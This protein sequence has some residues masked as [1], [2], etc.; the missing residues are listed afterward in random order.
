MP[1]LEEERPTY[2]WFQ[3]TSPSDLVP[4][5]KNQEE[6]TDSTGEPPTPVEEAIRTSTSR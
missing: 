1:T 5:E 2:S 4:N 6:P 3:V